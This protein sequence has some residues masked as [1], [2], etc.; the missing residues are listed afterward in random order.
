M[1]T[2]FVKTNE[3]TAARRRVYFYCVDAT[4][5]KTPELTEA[6]GQ[7]QCSL[8]GE[9]YTNTGIGVLVA[10]GNGD[11]YADLTQAK[12]N[13]ANGVIK[14]RY[15]SANTAEAKGDVV[16]IDSRLDG[17]ADSCLAAIIAANFATLD[18]FATLDD[19]ANEAEVATAVHTEL[20]SIL[21]LLEGWLGGAF[22]FEDNT[23]SANYITMKL[24]SAAVTPVLL[25]T[26]VI[27][28]SSGDRTKGV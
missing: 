2:L 8:D 3:A 27:T 17:V 20:D 6:G 5:V 14:T 19:F 4:D 22:T 9:A 1:S 21:T 10:A 26:W 15:K 12:V 18:E 11:Y 25:K 13:V 23:P 16:V 24:Y 28:K 7:P